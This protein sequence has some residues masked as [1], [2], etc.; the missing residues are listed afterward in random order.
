MNMRQQA[1]ADLA[2]T[3]EGEWALPVVLI[4]PDGVMD[5]VE[6]QVLYDSATRNPMTGEQIVV[7]RPVVTLRRS[8]LARIPKQNENWLVRIPITPNPQA[9]TVDFLLDQTNAP[10]GGA[11][12]GF[13]RLYMKAARH[14]PLPPLPP[15]EPPV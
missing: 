2:F 9:A 3:L 5:T 15:P 4:S 12:L 14:V 10:D 13:I 1:E 6:G 7:N 8:S 11:S